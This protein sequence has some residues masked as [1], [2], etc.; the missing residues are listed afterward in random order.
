M[1]RP[2]SKLQHVNVTRRVD[3]MKGIQFTPSIPIKEQDI[4]CH[5]NLNVI[6]K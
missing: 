5:P 2:L 6:K 1:Q 4:I 3:A